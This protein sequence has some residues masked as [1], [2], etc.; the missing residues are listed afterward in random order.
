MAIVRTKAYK[1]EPLVPVAPTY[2]FKLYLPILLSYCMMPGIFSLMRDIVNDSREIRLLFDTHGYTLTGLESS[3][4]S[5]SN[6][7]FPEVWAPAQYLI[8]EGLRPALARRLSSTYMDFAARYKETCQSHFDRATH[9][10]HL[11]E[12]HREVFIILFKR[13]IQALGS[14]LVSIVRVWLCQAGA[15][16]ATVRP[17]RVDVS[18]FVISKPVAYL[19]YHTDTRGRRN[20]SRNYR[21]TRT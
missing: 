13:T 15:S 6:L 18:I 10:G 3:T 14:Y 2:T 1:Y 9:G 5:Q 16:Q 20:E 17:E 19:C 7:H 11:A 8:D 4:L 12:H 21:E